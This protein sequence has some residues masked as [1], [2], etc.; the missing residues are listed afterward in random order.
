MA[1]RA[2]DMFCRNDTFTTVDSLYRNFTTKEYF[3]QVLPSKKR[4]GSVDPVDMKP[5]T[6]CYCNPKDKK[7]AEEGVWMNL[8][9][10]NLPFDDQLVDLKSQKAADALYYVQ[11]AV[12][13]CNRY[14]HDANQCF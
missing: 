1:R 11:K 14:K 9:L 12:S 4:C 5:D 8:E 3:P 7:G 2:L 6:K 10:L 13:L